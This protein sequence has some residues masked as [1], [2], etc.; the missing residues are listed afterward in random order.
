MVGCSAGLLAH[1]QRAL[2]VAT[3]GSTH[4]VE[5]QLQHVSMQVKALALRLLWSCTARV[6]AYLYNP[7]YCVLVLVADGIKALEEL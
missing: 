2:A 7:G 6:T 4:S 3:T 1:A 5:D